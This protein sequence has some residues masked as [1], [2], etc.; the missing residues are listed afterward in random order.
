MSTLIATLIATFLI[1]AVAV[2]IINYCK[3]RAEN[4]RHGLT[5]M[6]H[7]SGGASCCSGSK[8]IGRTE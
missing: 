2:F 5:G 6:C 4:N 3:K 8:N 7:C 1:F